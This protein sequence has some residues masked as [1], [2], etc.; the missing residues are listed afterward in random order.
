MLVIV[1][2]DACPVVDMHAA[3]LAI[4]LALHGLAFVAIVPSDSSP[5]PSYEPIA[6]PVPAPSLEDSQGEPEP[7]VNYWVQ[8]GPH[9]TNHTT[10][11]RWIVP[12]A[13]AG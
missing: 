7:L 9:R 8:P 2:S 11:G 5:A 4:A 10:K 1:D 12:L 6:P 3:V 13:G